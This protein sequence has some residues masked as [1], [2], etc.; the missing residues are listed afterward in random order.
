MPGRSSGT[1]NMVR[2]LCFGAS[3][4]VLV[5]RKTYWQ[6]C[7]PVVNIFE[8]LITQPVAVAHRTGLAGRDVGAALGFGVAEAQPDVPA[9]DAGNHL[10]G[11]ARSDPNLPTDLAIIAVVPDVTHGT[12][13]RRFSSCHNRPRTLSNPPSD[14]GF[15]SRGKV[16]R[17]TE[18]Q[19]NALVEVVAGLPVAADDVLGH[20]IG[21][22]RA[23]FVEKRLI[24]VGQLN[25]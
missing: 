15:H 24:V 6:L 9:E 2:L 8:P 16:T 4:S 10:L 18:R 21:Q 11:G 3:G 17:R 12:C 19:V 5:I 13:A 20:L 25:P 23:R 1:R 7:A 14:S 22:E